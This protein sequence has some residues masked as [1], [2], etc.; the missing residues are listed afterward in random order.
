MDG[1]Q[2]A[3]ADSVE[4]VPPGRLRER[5]AS[6]ADAFVRGVRSGL[7]DEEA[8]AFGCGPHDCA[9]DEGTSR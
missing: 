9:D 3:G 5:I 4:P 7:D 2:S 8:F 1:T 6:D